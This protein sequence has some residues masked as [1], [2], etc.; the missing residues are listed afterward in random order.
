MWT[1]HGQFIHSF[2]YFISRNTDYKQN[3]G[4]KHVT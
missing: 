2:I 4:S 1:D 3:T